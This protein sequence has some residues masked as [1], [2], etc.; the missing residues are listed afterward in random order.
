MPQESDRRDRP[1]FNRR[2]GRVERAERSGR[3]TIARNT[4]LNQSEP[5]QQER[6]MARQEREGRN[7]RGGRRE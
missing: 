2:E 3:Q 6:R 5:R 7:E 1:S 4:Q